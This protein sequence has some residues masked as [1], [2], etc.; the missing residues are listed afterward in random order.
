MGHLITAQEVVIQCGLERIVF[1]PSARPPHKDDRPLTDARHRFEMT[2]LA[3]ETHPHFELSDIEL[4][5][6]G[7]S[8]TVDTL[9]Q[10]QALFGEGVELYFLIGTDNV[11]EMWTW[12]NPGEILD[13]CTV[14]VASRPG[15]KPDPSDLPLTRRMTFV[16]TPRIEISSTEIRARVAAGKPITY[17]VP[18]AVER[19]IRT[20]GLYL[21]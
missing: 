8:Y 21:P 17:W 7:T 9:K 11:H 4:E 5:R 19:Y 13:L 6:P 12:R 1:V 15:F 3:I 20:H 18:P 16:W 14:V 2:A 10:M